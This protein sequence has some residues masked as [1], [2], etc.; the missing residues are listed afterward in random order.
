VPGSGSASAP[1]WDE[2]TK[3]H[4]KK[5]RLLH[6]N[7]H[8]FFFVLFFLQVL[9]TQFFFHHKNICGVFYYRFEQRCDLHQQ[10]QQVRLSLCLSTPVRARPA[11]HVRAYNCRLSPCWS[12]SFKRF[13]P[14]NVMWKS[15]ESNLRHSSEEPSSFFSKGARLYFG[16]SCKSSSVS[17]PPIPLLIWW[18]SL[19]IADQNS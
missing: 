10:H 11:A 3:I 1:A 19:H 8:G 4:P 16:P 18:T 12:P 17:S 2:R 13:G 15:D 14:C 6:W 5:F 7:D 9:A